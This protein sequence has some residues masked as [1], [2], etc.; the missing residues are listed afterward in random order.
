MTWQSTARPKPTFS[1]SLQTPALLLHKYGCTSV[2]FFHVRFQM[3]ILRMQQIF[4]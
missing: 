3:H 1:I 4:S 2:M